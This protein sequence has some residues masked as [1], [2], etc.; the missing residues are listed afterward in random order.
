MCCQT[1]AFVIDLHKTICD[2]Q[3]HFLFRVLI[4]TGIPVF[5]IHD[6]EVQVYRPAI[7]P[8]GNLIR[9]IRERAKVFLLFLKYLIAATITFLE[10]LMV[11]F[12][13]SVR[14]PLFELR[15]GVVNVVPASGDN[16]GSYLTDR[17][18]YGRLLLWFPDT[19]GHDRRHVMR[20]Q[21]CIIIGQDNLAFLGMRY[22]TGLE[23]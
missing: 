4:R 7:D 18:F 8:L 9:D 16:G 13:E 6:M 22:N 21:S 11:E 3:I 1:L 15:E 19:C 17:A 23:I 20:S 2:L 10:S 14:N 5:L 12:I